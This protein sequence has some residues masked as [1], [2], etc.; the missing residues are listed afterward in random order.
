M[1]VLAV[2]ALSIVLGSPFGK[3]EARAVDATPGLDVEVEVV[4]AGEPSVVLARGIGAAGELGPVPLSDA[5]QGRWVGILRLSAP[6]NIRLGF[7]AIYGEGKSELSEVHN[8]ETYGVDPAVL[9]TGRSATLVTDRG[10]WQTNGVLL[11]VAALAAGAA[12]V[13]IAYWA[14][15]GA[16]SDGAEPEETSA[17][18]QEP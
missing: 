3:A 16:V 11:V 6:E 1:F 12:L 14:I 10:F 4:V 7:E 5:G 17:G 8:L 9:S 18:A 13:L 15:R 2:A